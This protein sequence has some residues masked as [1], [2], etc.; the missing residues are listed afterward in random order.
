MNKLDNIA[1]RLIKEQLELYL[2]VNEI[3]SKESLEYEWSIK[4]SGNYELIK[5]INK[6]KLQLVT[7]ALFQFMKEQNIYTQFIKELKIKYKEEKNI[8]KLIYSTLDGIPNHVYSYIL[9][10]CVNQTTT[11][12]FR[13][14]L[15]NLIPQWTN[16]ISN[17]SRLFNDKLLK[18]IF[19]LC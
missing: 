2:I 11:L 5:K 6:L 15:V 9:C 17:F 4:I 16:T 12:N 1:L 18:I 8:P 10:I 7:Y 14:K 13:D 3:K 19:C